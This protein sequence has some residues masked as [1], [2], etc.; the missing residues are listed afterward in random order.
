MRSRP[1]RAGAAAGAT[2]ALLVGGVA[3]AAPSHAGACSK[4][5]GNSNQLM[6]TGSTYTCAYVAASGNKSIGLGNAQSWTSNTAQGYQKRY[7]CHGQTG[8]VTISNIYTNSGG[9]NLGSSIT[10]TA[11]NG[12]SGKRHWHAAVL[13][14]TSSAGSVSSNQYVQNCSTNYSIGTNTVYKSNL[15]LSGPS[16]I[17][18]GTAATFTASISNPDGGPAP[19]GKIYLFKEATAN[20]KNPPTKDC[21]GASTNTKSPVDTAVAQGVISGGVATLVTPTLSSANYNFYAVF[22]GLPLTSSELA[23]H[24]LAPPQAAGLTPQTSSVLALTAGVGSAQ[25]AQSDETSARVTSRGDIVGANPRLS[26]VNTT[27][28]APQRVTSRCTTGKVAAQVS[29]ASPTAVLDPDDAT[30]TKSRVAF[31]SSGLPDGTQVDLQL[32][33]RPK[34]AKAVVLPGVGWGSV[35]DDNM[36]TNRFGAALFGGFGND[37]LVVAD[38]KGMAW[39]GPGDDVIVLRAGRSAATGGPGKDRLVSLSAGRTL[40]RGGPGRDTLIGGPGRTLINAIDGSGGDKIVC[41][42]RNNIVLLDSGDHVTGPCKV[43]YVRP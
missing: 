15:S 8:G 16:S 32:V 40:L 34:G 4:T 39:G 36:T 43:K 37:N 33:C 19:S 23:G 12:S 20:V 1:V 35:R 3:L 42:S 13:W 24:C 22:G 28:I 25:V 18:A 6:W 29:L 26:V 27:F 17:A 14:N 21:S 9:T 38:T 30:R 11:F 2:L 41:R 31:N 7:N 5:G 10:Y